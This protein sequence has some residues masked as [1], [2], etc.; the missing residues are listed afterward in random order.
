MRKADGWLLGGP[1]CRPQQP[2]AEKCYLTMLNMIQ[3][4][5][6]TALFLALLLP[7]ACSGPESSKPLPL[8][9][10]AT[11]NVPEVLALYEAWF[12]HPEHISVGY[13]SHDPAVLTR[14]I[15]KAK[16]MGISA[17]VIDWYGDREP[18]I[19]KSYALMQAAA[20]KNKFKVAMMYDETNQVD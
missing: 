3:Y 18:F 20:E 19:D 13:S 8:K 7:H 16:S 17:F 10:K 11:G 2:G 14:Q 1:V 12:G 6:V 5:V 15:R 4:R 9:Y